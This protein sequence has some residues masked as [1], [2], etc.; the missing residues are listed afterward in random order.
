MYRPTVRYDDLFKE[1]VDKLNETTR[2]DSNQIMRLA[3]FLLGHTREGKEIINRCSLP[4]VTLPTPPWD[5]N[6]H[7]LWSN[8]N[9]LVSILAERE[10]VTS[11]KINGGGV[12][13]GKEKINR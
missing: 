9:G 6:N 12:T 8:S 11:I 3:L 13:Y 10:T 5:K 2:L 1:Y 4:D 7:K